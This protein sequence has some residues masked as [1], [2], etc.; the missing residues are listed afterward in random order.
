MTRLKAFSPASSSI[1]LPCSHPQT[2]CRPGT[3]ALDSVTAPC[4]V[5]AQQASPK[6][7]FIGAKTTLQ[8]LQSTG[9]SLGTKC[10][11]E[12]RRKKMPLRWT[13][14]SLLPQMT[15]LLSPIIPVLSALLCSWI[16]HWVLFPYLLGIVRAKRHNRGTGKSIW[17]SVK[18]NIRFRGQFIFTSFILRGTRFSPHWF[19]V[20]IDLKPAVYGSLLHVFSNLLFLLLWQLC[21]LSLN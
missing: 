3:C 15:F 12:C 18:G 10:P 4:L 1:V 6:R 8:S 20:F 9:D 11:Q 7:P 21:A 2:L 5:G 16:R 14:K 13:L 19:S 17:L